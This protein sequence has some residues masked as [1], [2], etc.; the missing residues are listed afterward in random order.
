MICRRDFPW[1]HKLYL[2]RGLAQEDGVV[3]WLVILIILGVIFVI[4]L[5][6]QLLQ[7]IF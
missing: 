6:V 5:V 4:W 2:R 3:G 7:A 1:E